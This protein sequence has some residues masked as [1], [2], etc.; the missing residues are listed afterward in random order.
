[1]IDGFPQDLQIVSFPLECFGLLLVCI[2]IFRE[3]RAE[4]IEQW[5]DDI[6]IRV[7]RIDNF[8]HVMVTVAA[9]FF[10]LFVSMLYIT[11]DRAI[12]ADV[13]TFLKS[14]PLPIQFVEYLA[15]VS[16]VA[17]LPIVGV[18]G[19]KPLSSSVI[20]Y[21]ND[22]SGGNALGT[23]GF[24]TAAAGLACETMQMFVGT[25]LTYKIIG[26]SVLVLSGAGFMRGVVRSYS[27]EEIRG[28]GDKDVDNYDWHKKH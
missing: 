21:L 2:E 25:P 1:M 4:R 9:T 19:V 7:R 22:A 20:A 10:A 18:M 24:L 13:T 6:P 28:Y 17:A 11:S 8:S 3:Y 15:V 14:D 12:V 5:I 23:L 16:I 27:K 26:A